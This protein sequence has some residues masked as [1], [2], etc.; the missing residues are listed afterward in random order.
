MLRI[1]RKVYCPVVLM[2]LVLSVALLNGCSKRVPDPVGTQSMA[3]EF[4]QQQRSIGQLYRYIQANLPLS[5]GQQAYARDTYVGIMAEVNTLSERSIGGKVEYHRLKYFVEDIKPLY[6]DLRAVLDE[7]FKMVQD[8][9]DT[10]LDEFAAAEY[11][12]TRASIERCFTIADELIARAEADASRDDMAEL[13]GIVKSLYGQ[14][15]PY[16]EKAVDLAL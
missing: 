10:L 11:F 13:T 7:P 14:L 2:L 15:G 4:A 16:F 12:S 9:P 5:P 6:R 8:E 3:L 1:L